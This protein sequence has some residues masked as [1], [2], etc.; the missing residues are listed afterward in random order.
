[1]GLCLPPKRPPKPPRA[2]PPKLRKR[3]RQRKRPR[4]AAE[5]RDNLPAPKRRIRPTRRFNCVLT[6]FRSA[7]IDWGCREIRAPIGWRPGD[8]SW[9]K[10]GC[11]ERPSGKPYG[12]ASIPGTHSFAFSI[13]RFMENGLAISPRTPGSFNRSCARSSSAFPEIKSNGGTM[14]GGWT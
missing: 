9:P 6:S 14:R 3:D 1:M 8:S 13:S 7:G 11:A 2:H 5:S 12:S 10:P 4:P